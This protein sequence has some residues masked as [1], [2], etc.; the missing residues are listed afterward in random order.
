MRIDLKMINAYFLCYNK[1]EIYKVIR[2]FDVKQ[3]NR[4]EEIN[5][6]FT[7]KRKHI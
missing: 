6:Y 1:H 5:Q 2:V 4:M 3:E 7:K